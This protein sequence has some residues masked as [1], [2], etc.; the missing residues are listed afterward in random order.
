MTEPDLLT[1]KEFARYRRCSLRTL[2]RE[3]AEGRGCAYIRIGSR[4]LYRRIDIERYMD[5]H[6]RGPTNWV[7]NA[8]DPASI[9]I[10]ADSAGKSGRVDPLPIRRDRYSKAGVKAV[11]S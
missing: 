4:V 2:D 9:A 6:V 1:P 10:H 7:S 8:A 3:R 11:T 5:A